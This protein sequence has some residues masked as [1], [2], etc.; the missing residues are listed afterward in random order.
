MTALAEATVLTAA[1]RDLLESCE[2]TISRGLETFREVGEA[3]LQ[4]RDNRLYRTD[5]GTFEEYVET[6]WGLGRS[7]ANRLVAASSVAAI[8]APIGA[9]I[10]NEAQARELAPLLDNP[11]EMRVAFT[12]A[13][14]RSNGKPA[15]AVIRD[16]VR[17]RMDP[18]AHLAQVAMRELDKADE[19]RQQVEEHNTWARDIKQNMPAETIAFVN[20]LEAR[21]APIVTIQFGCQYFLDAVQGIDPEAAIGQAIDAAHEKLTI[22]SDAIAF[23]SRVEQAL[24]AQA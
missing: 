4:V 15:A 16:V 8:L 12:D 19:K 9:E 7:Y 1:E 17:E 24:G 3:L 5:F 21:L 23:L 6:R 11:E 13:V 22:V 18:E 14:A 20:D 2:R 10:K